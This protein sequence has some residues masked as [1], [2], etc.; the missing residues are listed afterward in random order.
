MLNTDLQ[1]HQAE[2]IAA[3]HP[4][5]RTTITRVQHNE[6]KKNHKQAMNAK[7]KQHTS[8]ASNGIMATMETNQSKYAFC[9]HQSPA[10]Q[11][12]L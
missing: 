3:L 5:T 12:D 4:K 7:I 8:D 9:E 10:V 6:M 1:S 2:Y 11:T